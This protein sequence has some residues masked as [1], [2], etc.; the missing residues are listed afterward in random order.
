MQW[1]T[2]IHVHIAIASYTELPHSGQ[3]AC[4]INIVVWVVT[5]TDENALACNREHG[6]SLSVVMKDYYSI[7]LL[8]YALLYCTVGTGIGKPWPD[9]FSS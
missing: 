7:A 1:S 4:F 3:Q 2:P 8:R 9:H 6:L 5:P